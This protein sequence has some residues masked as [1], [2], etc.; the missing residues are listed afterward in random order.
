MTTQPT[1]AQLQVN[2][3][4]S[5]DNQDNN[6]DTDTDT[7][8]PTPR[9]AEEVNQ[10]ARYLSTHS[11]SGNL[12]EYERDSVFDPFGDK[13]DPKLWVRKFASL[14]DWG[15]DRASGVSFKNLSVFGYGSDAGESYLAPTLLSNSP[16][17]PRMYSPIEP[18][19][20]EMLDYQKTIANIP[21]SLMSSIRDLV[22]SNRKRKVTILNGMDG[23][24]EAG[25]MLVVLG[26]PGR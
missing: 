4:D 22:D 20:D 14:E 25:E 21:L 1:P 19:A 13:F 9:P 2:Q 12:F 10:L 8:G 5:Y 16:I 11:T 6:G 18:D 26:P 3:H 15:Q 23:V 7:V 24:L 17:A